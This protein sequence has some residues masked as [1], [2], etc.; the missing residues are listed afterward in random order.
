MIDYLV[1]QMRSRLI[2]EFERE[3]KEGE[4]EKLASCVVPFLDR[5]GSELKAFVQ[6]FSKEM[7]LDH[8]DLI[9]KLFILKQNMPFDMGLYMT[10]Q[11][12]FIERTV[13]QQQDSSHPEARREAV[14]TW[15]REN[16]QK[17]RHEAILKQVLCF[18]KVKER[19]LPVIR[20]AI[21]DVAP[22]QH[23]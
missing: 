11:K 13:Y 15:I 14:A 8:L 17:H 7:V 1:P 19:V 20:K 16:A 23:L 12:Q 3:Y 22:S 4:F 18:D 5:H 10:S 6:T 21:S 2:E 9:V